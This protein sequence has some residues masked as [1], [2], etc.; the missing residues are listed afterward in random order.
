MSNHKRMR[1]AFTLVELL[2]VIA[3]IGILIGMLLPA[4]QQVR[5]AARRSSCSNHL[6]QF[7]LGSLNFES[8]QQHLPT[9][10]WGYFWVGDA[11]RG[12]GRAQPGSWLYCLLPYVEQNALHAIPADGNADAIKSVQFKGGRTLATT[13]LS[14]FHCPSRRQAVLYPKRYDGDFI[15]YNA[16]ATPPTQRFLARS[17]Y[18]VNI[19]DR[20]S[21][22]GQQ[23]G[24]S[25][26]PPMPEYPAPNGSTDFDSF[27]NGIAFASS[28]VTLAQIS[29]GTTNTYF[30]GEKYLN[31]DN[32]ETG[33][34]PGDNESWAAGF[35][36]DNYRSG[37]NTPVRDTPG[38]VLTGR[39]GSAHTS[40]VLMSFCDGSVHNIPFAIDRS[41]NKNLSNREDGN[42]IQDY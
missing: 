7:S 27:F 39:F 30:Y 18:A 40:G 22:G 6:K 12:Y 28:Q 1:F 33:R 42:V 24:P 29:D 16:S 31:P 8:A 17:D 13:P 41:V 32:Y 34:D 38:L 20:V 37:L 26:M 19:G 21:F 23:R 11:D 25:T 4:V 9:G 5:E 2:V 14:I 15:A 36:N 35:N 10:G 3:I